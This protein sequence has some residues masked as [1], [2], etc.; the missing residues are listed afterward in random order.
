[1]SR[2]L[3]KEYREMYADIK[4]SG[5]LIAEVKEKMKK[6]PDLKKASLRKIS[7][8]CGSAAAVIAVVTMTVTTLWN[9]GNPINIGKNT[10]VFS[11]VGDSSEQSDSA[12]EQNLSIPEWYK[13]GRLNVLALLQK[14]KS[15][16]VSAGIKTDLI[17]RKSVV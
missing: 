10:S 3:D 1:M 14:T 7:L 4:P 12:S 17:D 11:S 16:G 9:S 6:E 13:P 8:W 2:L 5:L 15:T